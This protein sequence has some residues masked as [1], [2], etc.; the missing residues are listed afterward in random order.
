M[1]WYTV[2]NSRTK[3]KDYCNIAPLPKMS[4]PVAKAFREQRL[5]AQNGQI[6]GAV[7]V[8]ITPEDV[9]ILRIVLTDQLDVYGRTIRCAEGLYGTSD[10]IRREWPD[11]VLLAAGLWQ[12]QDNW[13]TRII[14]GENIHVLKPEDAVALMQI[15]PE[16]LTISGISDFIQFTDALCSF[17]IDQT[18]VHFAQSTSFCGRRQWTPIQ[19]KHRYKIEFRVSKAEKQAWLEGIDYDS[20]CI[21]VQ[22][23]AVKQAKSGYSIGKLERSA[24]AIRIYMNRYGWRE[25]K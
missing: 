2:F 12:Q 1:K 9:L 5:D 22:S 10:D 6:D 19:K 25:V 3:E 17:T 13:Y 14:D 15:A 18:G 16:D 24:E 8:T 11:I 21:L 7:H 20:G 23:M 4:D